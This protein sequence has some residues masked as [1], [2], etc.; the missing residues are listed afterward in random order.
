M[1]LPYQFRFA[2]ATALTLGNAGCG[3]AGVLALALVGQQAIFV[4]GALVF[5]AWLFDTCDGIAARALGVSGPF[6]AMLDSLCD[7]VSFGV[8]PGLIAVTAASDAWRW[9]AIVAAAAY[10]AAAL[11]RLSRYTVKAASGAPDEHRLWFQGISSPAA[12]MTVAAAALVGSDW[13]AAVAAA[14]TAPIM[15]SSLPYPDLTRFY[16]ERRVPVW[17]LA[18]PLIAL[19]LVPW[20]TVLL[21]GFILY[22]LGGPLLRIRRA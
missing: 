2:T 3:F 15:V 1:T 22:V 4:A 8:L 11:L 5:A 7:A 17:T 20:R 6:G 16:L 9:L 13:G 14:V 19:A 12:A 10:L 18:V 21:A